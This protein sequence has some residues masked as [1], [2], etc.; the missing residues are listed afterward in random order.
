MSCPVVQNQLRIFSFHQFRPEIGLSPP[1][2][3]K[4]FPEQFLI[5]P[6][7]LPLSWPVHTALLSLG[8]ESKD[9]DIRVAS[10]SAPHVRINVF[11]SRARPPHQAGLQCDLASCFLKMSYPGKVIKTSGL[12]GSLTTGQ[13]ARKQVDNAKLSRIFLR[14]ADTGN[15]VDCL[16]HLH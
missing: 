13:D 14:I 6:I 5:V 4:G 10:C 15:P 7:S 3:A 16:T 12:Q 9:S 1:P 2:L 11:A 8:S